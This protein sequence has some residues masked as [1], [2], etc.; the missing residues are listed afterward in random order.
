TFHHPIFPLPG[1]QKGAWM[2]Q[3]VRLVPLQESPNLAVLIQD[4]D[5]QLSYQEEIERLVEARTAELARSEAYQRAILHSI[6]EAVIVTDPEWKIQQWL[7]ASQAL[8]GWQAAE[9]RGRPL[10]SVLNAVF[11]NPAHTPTAIAQQLQAKARWEGMLSLQT[12]T[13]EVRIFNF[14]ATPLP[15][16]QSVLLVGNDITRERVTRAQILRSTQINRA[17]SA[18]LS[19]EE[20]RRQLPGWLGEM[21]TFDYLALALA[22]DGPP[23]RCRLQ[24]FFP[25]FAETTL[26]LTGTPLAVLRQTHAPL[27]SDRPAEWLYHPPDAPPQ[28][29]INHLLALPLMEAEQVHGALYLGTSSNTGFHALQIELLEHT[30]AQL[31]VALNTVHLF[32]ANR[33][34]TLQLRDLSHKVLLAQEEERARLA[35]ELHD[36]IGQQLTAL[37]L[38]LQQSIELLPQE[39]ENLLREILAESSALAER[40]LAQVR[41]LSLDLRPALLD[42]LGLLPALRWLLDR[43]ARTARLSLTLEAPSTLPRLSPAVETA[44]F[45][46]LQEAC[47]N[48]QRHA[49]A[50]SLWFKTLATGDRIEFHLSDDGRGF[51][52]AALGRDTLGLRNMRE[53]AALIAAQLEIESAP[54]KGTRLSLILPLSPD[55]GEERDD[56]HLAGG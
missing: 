29:Q 3:F 16:Q 26:P 12:G 44:V 47:S 40:L 10:W 17:I 39:N 37:H 52:P 56:H 51:D 2:R 45:R 22:E 15:Q 54:G 4:V 33:Q 55:N 25:T 36:H 7:G 9:V 24:V 27:H 41:D 46:I 35:R 6:G 13:G 21:A 50:R 8:L 42:D 5:E 14:T 38:N 20:L 31:A 19:P 23:A 18:H 34:M 43:T 11:E 49:Q 53:R 32:D 28:A 48:V 30:A 1:K